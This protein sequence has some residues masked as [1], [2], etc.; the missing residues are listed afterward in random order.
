MGLINYLGESKVIKRICQLLNVTD[1]KVDGTSVVDSNGVANIPSGGTDVDWNQILDSGTKIAEITIDEDEPVEVFAP[2]PTDVVANPTGTAST[3][4]TK[5]KVG[6]QTFKIP[7]TNKFADLTDVDIDT[8][9]LADGQ[10]PKWNSTTH[11]W[12]NGEGGSGS[13]GHNIID[14]N[15]NSM[16]ARAGLQFIGGANVSDDS[17][18]NKTIVDLASAGGIDGVFIDIGN[19]IHTISDGNDSFKEWIATDD[20]YIIGTIKS[21][22]SP[23]VQIDGITVA[24]IVSTSETIGVCVLAKKGQSVKY[25]MSA[26]STLTAYGIQTGTTHS[27]FQP[28]IYST[29]ER[30]I[31]VWTDGK[32]LYEKTFYKLNTQSTFS[33]FIKFADIDNPETVISIL[34]N[35]KRDLGN[36]SYLLYTGDG[37]SWTEAGVSGSSYIEGYGI[38][39][40]VSD[41]GELQYRI[42]QYGTSI[43]DIWATVQYTKSTDTAGSG[44]WTPQGTPAVHYSTSEQVIGTWID[45]KTLYQKTISLTS[46]I[47]IGSYG[48]IDLTNDIIIRSFEGR[49]YRNNH[50]TVDKFN[51]YI[52]NSQLFCTIRSNR[53]EYYISNDF[54]NVEEVVFVLEYTKE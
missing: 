4:L 23:A 1:V 13:G 11:K 47:S 3:D 18:N 26:Q 15:G 29:E 54:T 45:N 24:Y 6:N 2:T 14:E 16:T 46:G 33:D 38:F 12:E 25:R 42:G 35:A 5:L 52:S 49:V 50:K 41:S 39:F 53:I 10:V 51:G 22:Q 30:E 21:S 28:V 9:T 44:T 7:D 40:R 48:Y 37:S 20:C 32:P 31:G 27:K 8:T 43:T 36:N 19:V 17:T 34:W